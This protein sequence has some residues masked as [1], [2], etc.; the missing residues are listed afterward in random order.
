[1]KKVTVTVTITDKGWETKIDIGGQIFIE[2]HEMTRTGAKMVESNLDRQSDIPE[3]LQEALEG[4][5]FYNI[6]NAL[7]GR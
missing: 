6:S 2:K 1:M 4:F 7:G 5:A 3:E